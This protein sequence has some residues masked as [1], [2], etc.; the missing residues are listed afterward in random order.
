M[1]AGKRWAIGSGQSRV[2]PESRDGPRAEPDPIATVPSRSF[3]SPAAGGVASE[4]RVGSNRTHR[5]SSPGP[6]PVT[7]L[8]CNAAVSRAHRSQSGRCASASAASGR[9]VRLVRAQPASMARPELA[10][11]GLCGRPHLRCALTE[12]RPPSGC[13]IPGLPSEGAPRKRAC[14]PSAQREGGCR[15]VRVHRLCRGGPR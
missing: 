4:I 7:G 9:F 2:G 11:A 1:P 12:G 15:R 13:H 14:P 6:P 8:A 5:A 3:S 10:C